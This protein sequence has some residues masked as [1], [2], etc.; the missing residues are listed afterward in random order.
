MECK[1]C[2]LL[3]VI[4]IIFLP[5]STLGSNSC[6]FPA[7]FNFGDS[8]SDT[9]GLAAAFGQPP[10][11]YGQTFFHAPA[12]RQSDGRLVLDFITQSLG[13]P[14]LSSFL[15]SVGS[16]FS[17]GANFATSASTI[18]PQNL[19]LSRGGYSPISLDVQHVEYSDF[20]TRSQIVRKQRG[21]FHDLLP[22]KDYFSRA[23]YTFDIGQ[24]DL[25]AGYDLNLTTEEVKA[26]VPD[27]LGQFSNVIKQIYNE[28]GRSFWIHNTGPAG[29][30]TYVIDGLAATTPQVD[31]YG[32][33]IRINEVSQHFNLKLHETVLQLR[34]ELPLAAIIYVD[35]YSV[36]YSLISQAKKLGFDDPFQVCCGYGGKYNYNRFARCGQTAVVN[37]TEVVAKSCKDPSVRINWDG[38]HFTEAAN[39]WIFDHIADGSFSDPPISLNSA[40]N[41]G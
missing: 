40:C 14:Y 37:G 17:H 35:V 24:N 32:C 21:F 34:K 27:M 38:V 39:K 11:P 31:R 15:D 4:A 29:C 33:L 16:N 8:N 6:N 26:Q 9:G 23:L 1:V 5:T 19:S 10:P 7:I 20:L 3:I 12:G 28:G 18:R 36:K 2:T 13:L 22:E 30:L 25:T 41:R